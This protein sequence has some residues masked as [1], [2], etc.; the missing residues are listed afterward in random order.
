MVQSSLRSDGFEPATD[1]R[2]REARAPKSEY[3]ERRTILVISS[4]LSIRIALLMKFPFT[5]FEN[6]DYVPYIEDCLEYNLMVA[7]GFY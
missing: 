1:I 5:A 2:L 3:T 6:F 7:K 4:V